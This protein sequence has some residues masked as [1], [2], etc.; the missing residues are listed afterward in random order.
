MS[1]ANVR[2]DQR[3]ALTIEEFAESIAASLRTDVTP[4]PAEPATDTQP[5]ETLSFRERVRRRT[6]N[7]ALLVFRVGSELFAVEL[8]A[9]EEALDMPEIHRLPEMPPQM[10][11][12]FTQRGNLVSV[13]STG[14]A[15]GVSF[16]EAATVVVFD[17][18]ERRV[19]IATDDVDDVLM[20][21]LSET[22]DAPGV[23]LNDGLL[24]GVVHRGPELI[25]LLDADA[26]VASHSNL[27]ATLPP[28][29]VDAAKEIT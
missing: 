24:L 7:A 13:F 5:G 14:P 6:G 3:P 16:Q 17:G 20:V 29:T 12:V 2:D 11:G 8:A 25:A 21:A 18:G 26:L 22:R 23:N 28:P 10:L 15:L 9:V 1:G 27:T 4:S 19:A